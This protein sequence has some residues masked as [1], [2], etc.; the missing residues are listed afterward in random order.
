MSRTGDAAAPI[1]HAG[2][3]LEPLGVV[4]L[5]EGQQAA[6]LRDVAHSPMQVSQPEWSVGH[7]PPPSLGR[8][9]RLE[10]WRSW[11]AV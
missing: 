2:C 7:F 8:F 9:V 5:V 4:D 3:P 11:R 6:I 1:D 10:G